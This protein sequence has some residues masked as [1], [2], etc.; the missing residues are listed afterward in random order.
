VPDIALYLAARSPQPQQ[1]LSFTH[2]YFFNSELPSDSDTE[3]KFDVQGG[4]LAD[5]A[6]EI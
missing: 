1:N 4:V 3:K 6:A 5:I 2:L